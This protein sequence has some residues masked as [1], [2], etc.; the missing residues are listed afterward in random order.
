[1]CSALQLRECFGDFMITCLYLTVSVSD[2]NESF[3][4]VI[5]KYYRVVISSKCQLSA[6][7]SYLPFKF[8][9]S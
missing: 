2:E 8:N 7:T 3:T 5:Y 1:M 6:V 9:S 4:C